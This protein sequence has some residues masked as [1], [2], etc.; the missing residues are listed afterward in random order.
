M[1]TN[2]CMPT[3]NTFHSEN[4]PQKSETRL[5]AKGGRRATNRAVNK[6][7]STSSDTTN[8]RHFLWPNE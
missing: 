4:K 7:M 6:R 3:F 8:S 5:L 1:L 2:G